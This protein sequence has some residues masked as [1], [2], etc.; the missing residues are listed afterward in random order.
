MNYKEITT[1]TGESI[2]DI[3][4]ETPVLLVFLRHFGCIFCREALGDLSKKREAFKNKNVEIVFVHM[5][6][7]EVAESYFNEYN[8]EGV[9]HISDENTLLY[10]KFGLVKGNFN[11]LFGFNTWVRGFEAVSKGHM[12][13]MR[14]V[15]DSLQMPGIFLIDKGQLRN[16]YIHKRVSDSPD[17]DK[18]ISVVL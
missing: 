10:A 18:L 11:Q 17:Y 2:Y 15:G 9:R 13:A 6:P 8:L 1:N 5:S 7:N 14:G 12:W 3:S 16:S 4:M